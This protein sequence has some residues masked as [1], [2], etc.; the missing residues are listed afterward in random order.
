[1]QEMRVRALAP[2]IFK[3][4]PMSI[5]TVRSDFLPFSRPDISETE[6]ESVAD[7]LRSGWITTGAQTARFEELFREYSHAKSAV[8]LASATAGMHCVFESLNL[9]EGDEIITP[10]MTWVS[11]IN[12][13]ALRGATP[14]FIDV[15]RDTLMVS[16]EAVE[17]AITPKTRAVI[18][19]H[20][21]GAPCDLTPLRSLCEKHD[22]VLIEDAA[23]AA[24]TE[25]KGEK[26]GLRGT[27]IFSFHPIKNLT[28]GEGGMVTSDDENLIERVRRMKFHG[29]GVDAFD[30]DTHGRTP[31][32]EV[33][34]PGYKYN[35]TDISA[36]LG[37][38]QLARL[39]SFIERRAELAHLY[40]EL[41]AEIIEI[42]PL[43]VPE[44]SHRHAWH[45]FIVRV[46]A[47]ISRDELMAELKARNIGTGLH[48]RAAHTQKFYRGNAKYAPRF[49]LE[50]TQWNNDRICS[51]PLFPAM[52][53]DDVHD[54]VKAI[55]AIFAARKTTMRVEKQFAEATR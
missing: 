14:V 5:E 15:N 47:E 32:A 2:P 17:A 38:G 13:L 20:F 4:F 41:L 27:A 44:Y 33:I 39:D 45:L 36:A 37:I 55:K 19:V 11:T 21:A 23:H 7:V 12:L 40:L 29:L 50:N 42:A 3:S 18:P 16:P 54:V 51:L 25:Y 24:G 10:S 26:I 6:I 28:T 49:S 34:E 53:N 31:Q 22:L 46:L 30:R 43:D 1:M 52:K 9:G 48:F 8:A 35:L